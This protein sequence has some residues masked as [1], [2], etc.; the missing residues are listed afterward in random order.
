MFDSGPG[1]LPVSAADC[2]HRDG[3]S[4]GDGAGEGDRE[5]TCMTVTAS[6]M[7]TRT[8]NSIYAMAFR[9]AL[10]ARAYEPT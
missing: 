2:G 7:G 8:E 10:M 4:T 1:V 6:Y 9:Q 5:G 3:G